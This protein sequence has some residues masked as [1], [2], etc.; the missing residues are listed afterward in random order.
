ML[1][2]AAAAASEQAHLQ[3]CYPG[4]AMRQLHCSRASLLGALVMNHDGVD[5]VAAFSRRICFLLTMYL[6]CKI[7]A[8]TF[9]KRSVY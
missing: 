6:P 4:T 3:S 7:V 5:I 1:S 2:T 9:G 8:S